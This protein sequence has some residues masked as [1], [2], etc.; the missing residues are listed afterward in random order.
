MSVRRRLFEEHLANLHNKRLAAVEQLFLEH[1][2]SLDTPFTSVLP[3]ISDDPAVARLVPSSASPAG[4]DLD[5]LEELFEEWS[6]RR[7]ERAR[8]EFESMLGES[9]FVDFWGRMKKEGLDKAETRGI[10]EEE[11]GEEAGGEEGSGAVDLKA[12]A[13]LIDLKEIHAVLKVGS[14]AR[15]CPAPPPPRLML[16]TSQHD[17]RYQLFESDPD[18]RE[19]MMRVRQSFSKYSCISPHSLIAFLQGY[20][21]NL[22]APTRTVHQSRKN[23]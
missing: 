21:G 10:L 13:A 9:A 12:M 6:T 1:S 5:R 17:K 8:K 18:A 7:A 3:K 11:E 14:I 15:P 20:L 4:A 23:V 2:P 22:A 19:Q 16:H